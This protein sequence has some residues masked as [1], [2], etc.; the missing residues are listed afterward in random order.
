MSTTRNPQ[1]AAADASAFSETGPA[2][3]SSASGV[4][5]ALLRQIDW[6]LLPLLSCLY[7]ASYVNRGSIASIKAPLQHDLSISTGDYGLV[8]ALFTV[9]YSLAELF[10]NNLMVA[11]GARVFFTRIGLLWGIISSVMCLVPNFTWLLIFRVVL[12][13]AEA[14]LFPGVLLY[15]T[16]WYP[17][18]ARG[19]RFAIFYS[20]QPFSAVIA[21]PLSYGIL[22]GFSDGSGLGFAG[23]RWL[24]LLEGLPAIVL[25][26]MAW[27]M[28]ADSPNEAEW[29]TAEEK[30][31]LTKAIRDDENGIRRPSFAVHVPSSAVAPMASESHSETTLA[32]K[33]G[34]AIATDDIDQY[35]NDE[36]RDF[37]QSTVTMEIDESSRTTSDNSCSS[38]VRKAGLELIRT[39]K[40]VRM[41]CLIVGNFTSNST[42][43]KCRLMIQKLCHRVFQCAM[44]DSTAL[45]L[46]ILCWSFLNFFSLSCSHHRR[47][48][49]LS[50][51]ARLR[52]LLLGCQDGGSV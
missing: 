29:L 16:Y 22:K 15:F 20:A 44:S 13:V 17:S 19:E 51:I 27:Y 14:G 49:V 9:S 1:N 32:D 6:K 2:H 35:A 41:W 46:I 50:A 12:G 24:L 45:Q 48:V 39:L 47:L 23:W 36:E 26:L 5:A 11:Y 38:R 7:V 10:S 40:S 8:A 52:N 28:L 37:D 31:A 34:P 33:G 25:G 4:S 30:Q 43:M 21:A 3:A 18:H 42:I